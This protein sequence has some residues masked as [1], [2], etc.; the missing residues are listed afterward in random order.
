MLDTTLINVSIP[1]VS[2]Q[3]GKALV[4]SGCRVVLSEDIPY[5]ELDETNVYGFLCQIKQTNDGWQMIEGN[6]Y[7][8]Y[9]HAIL[10]GYIIKRHFIFSN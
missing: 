6:T 5:S 10:Q 7:Q 1:V 2:T 8:I 4:L 9:K 3:N